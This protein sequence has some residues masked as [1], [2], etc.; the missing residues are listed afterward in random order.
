MWQ[1]DSREASDIL[2]II[3]NIAQKTFSF[4]QSN[5]ILVECFLSIFKVTGQVLDFSIK[6]ILAMSKCP[7]LI[8]Q[9]RMTLSDRALYTL[10]DRLWLQE[11]VALPNP[12]NVVV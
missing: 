11:R 12:E 10:T 4:Y 1:V 5:I 7:C 6:L 8:Y 3:L 2:N 9:S